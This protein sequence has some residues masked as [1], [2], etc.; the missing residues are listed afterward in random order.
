[1]PLNADFHDILE[2]FI[3][4]N[5]PLLMNPLAAAANFTTTSSV[6]ATNLTTALS[7]TSTVSGTVASSSPVRTP[8][9]ARPVTTGTVVT[10]VIPPAISTASPAIPS[11]ALPP[12]VIV[13]LQSSVLDN[14]NELGLNADIEELARVFFA[15]LPAVPPA[16]IPTAPTTATTPTTPT[17]PTAPTISASQVTTTVVTSATTGSGVQV[18]PPGTMTSAVLTRQS[19]VEPAIPPREETPPAG[20]D[21]VN[22]LLSA[23]QACLG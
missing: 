14:F 16:N 8:T 7:S 4:T 1:M 9:G 17:T 22:E 20:E 13:S 15:N 6:A 10:A 5:L 19:P 3:Y 18:T 2:I 21:L 23:L 12:S 11:K